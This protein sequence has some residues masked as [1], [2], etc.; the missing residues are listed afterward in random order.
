MLLKIYYEILIQKSIIDHHLCHAYATFMTS[1]FDE[2]AI[3]IVD[4]RGSNQQTQSLFIGRDNSIELIEMTDTIGIGLLYAAMTQYIGFGL[5]QE[6]K[7]MGLAPFAAGGDTSA[8]QFKEASMGSL[9]NIQRFA[10][11]KITHLN[12]ICLLLKRSKKKLWELCSSTKVASDVTSSSYAKKMTGANYLCISGGV[13][14]N[15]VANHAVHSSGI[16][17]DLFINPA[18]SDTGI[19]LGAAYYGYHVVGSMPRK[20]QEVTSTGPTY[21]E[22]RIKMPSHHLT[23]EVIQGRYGRA[24]DLL[25]ENKIVGRFEGRSEMGPR[26]LGHRSLLMS[27]L[28]SKNK[29]IMNE[30]VKFREAFR[31]FAPIV[32]EEY[33]NEYFII[34]RP[35]RY[36][37]MIPPVRPSKITTI[38]AVTMSTVLQ[39]QTVTEF[40]V[41]YMISFCV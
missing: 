40:N 36:M 16:F 5:L 9:L 23:G 12:W 32:M 3:L 13:G 25:A 1:P 33:A 26:A 29:D 31:P 20:A 30:R 8:Y 15:S 14:L 19:P 4:G 27:P 22:A 24:I 6:G 34:D 37:L 18:A 10:T 17:K 41:V 38:P 21:S 2:A 28:L 7:T 11:R 35:C 39:V